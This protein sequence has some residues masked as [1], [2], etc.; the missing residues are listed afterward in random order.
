MKL[1]AQNLL[2]MEL[3]LKRFKV[4]KWQG[5]ECRYTAARLYKEFEYEG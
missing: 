4:L 5:L 2:K 1:L 3:R